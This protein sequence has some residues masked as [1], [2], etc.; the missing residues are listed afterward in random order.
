MPRTTPLTENDAIMFWSNRHFEMIIQKPNLEETIQTYQEEKM[1]YENR[2]AT[3]KQNFLECNQVN[4]SEQSNVRQETVENLSFW[5]RYLSWSYCEDCHLLQRQ[6][7]PFNF[8]NRPKPKRHS[9]RCKDK[10]YVIPDCDSVPLALCNLTMNDI[11]ILRPFDVDC[12]IYRRMQHGYRVKDGA[13]KIRPS[14]QSVTQKIESLTDRSQKQRCSTAYN[15]LIKCSH[16]SYKKF[17]DLRH[18]LL[19]TNRTMYL[20][21]IFQ[22]KGIECALWPPL[23]PFTSMCE[24]SLDGRE[25]RESGKAFFI[26]KAFSN[27]M[28]Y[29]LIFEVVHF[30]Y[31]R[32]LFKNIT[33]AIQSA[34][35][36]KCSPHRAL[37]SK[38]F[39]PGYWQW[40]HRFLLDAVS[41]YGL[42]FD[43]LDHQPL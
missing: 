14:E 31:D 15:Q 27:I 10:K 26:C 6:I 30:H 8:A 7:M 17:V 3:E 29:S 16:S 13:F 38:T 40:Q 23:Y 9:C 32:W 34:R 5:I 1:A 19:S 28:D 22:L 12:G 21:E 39:S 42:P 43:F 2:L 25:S 35:F 11:W 37:D 4:N 36:L 41:Q 20:S 33:G 18:E 24:S